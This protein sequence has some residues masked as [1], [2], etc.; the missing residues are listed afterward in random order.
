MDFRRNVWA[1]L[2]TSLVYC[3]TFV[4]NS[5][6]FSVLS[7]SAGTNWIFLPSGV[8]LFAILLF[9]LWGALGVILGELG[10]VLSQTGVTSDPG[11]VVG[12]VCLSG[13]AP[14]LARQICIGFSQ[15]DAEFRRMSPSV[16]LQV[17]TIFAATSASLHQ[18]WFVWR[19]I[20]D[21]FVSGLLV[22]FIGDVLG[23]LIVLYAAKAAL[24]VGVRRRGG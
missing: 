12:A 10:V 21:D 17:A 6:L 19:G 22:M 4:L 15:I 1:V 14:L 16:L 3:G 13:L 11:T 20:S 9:A 18:I 24:S 8:R 2:G 7:Y 23:T 5:Y